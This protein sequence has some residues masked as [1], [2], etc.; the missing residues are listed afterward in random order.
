MVSPDRWVNVSRD[1][2]QFARHVASSFV[3]KDVEELAN[4][5][6]DPLLHTYDP[7]PGSTDDPTPF[8]V[9]GP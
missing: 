8:D 9:A 3:D 6:R 5:G 7:T 2:V 4:A 1:N